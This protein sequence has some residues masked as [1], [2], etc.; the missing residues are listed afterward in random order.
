MSNVQ[1]SIADCGSPRPEPA[2]QRRYTPDAYL[3]SSARAV[4]IRELVRRLT[5]VPLSALVIS[6]DTGTGKGLVARIL[7][8]SGMRADGPLVEVNCAAL[9]REL[10]ESEL[11]GHEA[12][13]FTGARGRHRGYLEQADGGT[14]F[15]DEI[16]E[17]SPDLQA[18]LLTAIE[19]RRVRRVGGEAE[20]DVDVQVIAAS[21][22][23]LARRVHDGRFRCDLFHRLNVFRITLPALRERIEDLYQL[24]PKFVEEFSDLSRRAVCRVDAAIYRLMSRYHWPGNIRELRNVVER[25]VMLSDGA[26]LEERWLQLDF[27]DALADNGRAQVEGDRVIIPLDGSM[28][29]ADMDSYIIQA[30]LRRHRYNVTATARALNTTRET[31]RYR[32]QKYNLHD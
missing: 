28:A 25:A 2:V 27:S 1:L 3:G 4:E 17:L 24:V 14:L 30:A 22:R 12:G 13:S 31:L 8:H 11:F 15:L 29:L 18:K 19:D 20:F 23:D 10:A 26:G 5:G 21:N 16:G 32:I 7:H 9:P 6:G